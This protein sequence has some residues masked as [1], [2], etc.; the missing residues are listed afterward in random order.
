MTKLNDYTQYWRIYLTSQNEEGVRGIALERYIPHCREGIVY[1][2]SYAFKGSQRK[3]LDS[4]YS[5]IREFEATEPVHVYSREKASDRQRKKFTNLDIRG[6]IGVRGFIRD[7]ALDVLERG[8][9]AEETLISEEAI[10]QLLMELL[11]AEV[12]KEATQTKTTNGEILL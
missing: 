7:L 2:K 5:L 10:P 3:A 8:V 4:A 1:F 9:E 11:A 12:T 6:S